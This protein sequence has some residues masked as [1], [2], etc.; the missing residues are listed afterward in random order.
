LQTGVVV[1]TVVVVTV[2]VVVATH[3]PQ[4]TGQFFC[5]IAPN[6]TLLHVAASLPHAEGSGLPLQTPVVV[7]FVVV[8]ADV[9]LVVMVAV[10]VVLVGTVV[11]VPVVVVL[12]SV[13]VAMHVSQRT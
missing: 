7:V 8:V 5:I 6:T 4:S 2:A 9:V 1:V 12:V 11:V 10:V 13:V 3:A